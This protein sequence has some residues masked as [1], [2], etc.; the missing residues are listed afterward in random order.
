MSRQ[1]TTLR[2][3]QPHLATR[4]Q[5]GVRSMLRQIANHWQLLVLI[6]P[7]LIYFLVFKY[8]RCTAS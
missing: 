2:S 7:T 5:V 4:T 8:G 6:L 3:G 1:T